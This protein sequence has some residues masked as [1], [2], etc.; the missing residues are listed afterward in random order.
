MSIKFI[1]TMNETKILFTGM[2]KELRGQESVYREE[3]RDLDK[4]MQ[5]DNRRYIKFLGK[6]GKHF[7]AQLMRKLKN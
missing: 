5:K 1:L 6:F 7:L 4:E 3:L 2:I